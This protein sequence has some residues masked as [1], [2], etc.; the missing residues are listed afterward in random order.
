MIRR[1]PSVLLPAASL[2]LTG[3]GGGAAAVQDHRPGA[4]PATSVLAAPGSFPSALSPEVPDE[5]VPRKLSGPGPRTLAKVPSRTR[6][7]VVVVGAAASRA[8]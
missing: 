5:A 2:L 7:P 3:C 4:A 1:R 6:H 8:R